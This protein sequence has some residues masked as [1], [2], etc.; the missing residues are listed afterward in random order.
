MKYFL[1]SHLFLLFTT[2][3]GQGASTPSCLHSEEPYLT[4]SFSVKSNQTLET[5]DTIVNIELIDSHRPVN[6]GIYAFYNGNQIPTDHLKKLLR[7]GEKVTFSFQ[8]PH[9][10]KTAGVVHIFTREHP[11]I[12][13]AIRLRRNEGD[14]ASYAFIYDDVNTQRL[15][16]LSLPF[17]EKRFSNIYGTLIPAIRGLGDGFFYSGDDPTIPESQTYVK[18][19]TDEEILD[20][21]Q[22]Y[23]PNATDSKDIFSI[24]C[25]MDGEQF[26]AFNGQNIWA[27]ELESQQAA[28]LTVEFNGSL[29]SGW[30][31]LRC[32]VLNN[33]YGNAEQVSENI[34]TIAAMYIYK[35]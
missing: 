27:G 28:L 30:H 26:N 32:L 15:N 25:L 11:E 33:L 31:Q 1:L 18:Y 24:T 16:G 9:K 5:L 13:K 21:L 29:T 12:P 34:Y 8:I 2:V 23:F 20:N 4:F 3:I 6:F 17:D 22:F 10:V 14:F 35:P 7:C 19:L